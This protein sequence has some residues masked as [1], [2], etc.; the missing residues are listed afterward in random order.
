MNF[1]RLGSRGNDC[2]AL[3]KEVR[4]FIESTW[5]CPRC[6]R[7]HTGTKSIDI[8]IYETI[9][10]PVIYVI[11]GGVTIIK[12]ELVDIIGDLITRHCYIGNVLTK[13]KEINKKYVTIRGKYEVCIRGDNEKVIKC[14]ICKRDMF[15]SKDNKYLLDIP[16]N[17]QVFGSREG[18]IIVNEEIYNKLVIA[19]VRQLEAHVLPLLDSP[20]ENYVDIRGYEEI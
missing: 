14:E 13:S 12:K 9:T 16:E 8:E 5:L 18:F 15:F 7:P 17:I 3:T 6:C 11:T 10:K 20:K 1:Y 2:C 4:E 19:N